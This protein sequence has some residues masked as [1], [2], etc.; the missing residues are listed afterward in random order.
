MGTLPLSRDDELRNQD[1]PFAIIPEAYD[2]TWEV[3]VR[4]YPDTLAYLLKLACGAPTSVAGDG[5][6]TDQGGTPVPTGATRHRWTAPFGPSGASPLTAQVDIAYS[7]QST[8]FKAKGATVQQLDLSTPTQGG[9][10]VHAQG[11]AAYLSRQSNP[12]LT[13]AYESL[14]I[15]PFM[16]SNLTLPTNLSGTGTTEDFTLSVH[17]PVATV[18]SLGA[19]SKWADVVEKDNVGSI[20]VSGTIPKRQLDQDDVDA[21][22]NSTGFALL[23]SWVSDTFVTGSYP[24]K[25][26]F[27][28]SNA[29]YDAGDPDP[30]MNKRRHGHQLNWKSTTAS[31]GSS[32]FEVVNATASYA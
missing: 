15:R 28:A 1:E 29:Q 18:R 8:Y 25:F 32:V 7:D 9:A 6:I 19:A 3:K 26:Y 22:R 12:S 4:A 24:Y 5:V 30:L 13:P 27:S 23:A 31:T 14:S 2:P 11:P 17:N 16:R 20:V 21:L 10:Q